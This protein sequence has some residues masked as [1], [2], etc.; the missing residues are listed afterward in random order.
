MNFP[1][2]RRSIVYV[3][4]EET[5]KRSNLDKEDLLKAV[6]DLKRKSWE[7]WFAIEHYISNIMW[8]LESLQQ[9]NLS[10]SEDVEM[11]LNLY[12]RSTYKILVWTEP[13][14]FIRMFR[15]NLAK[16]TDYST[17]IDFK[18]TDQMIED[19]FKQYM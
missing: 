8:V 1:L 19:F 2:P 6:N 18:I 3:N 4:P 10:Y 5:D 15:R 14:D 13:K 17:N 11:E 7:V 12:K 9:W 16:N